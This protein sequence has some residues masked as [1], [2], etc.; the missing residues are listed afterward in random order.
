MQIYD[1]KLSDPLGEW[2]LDVDPSDSIQG[3]KQK[4][5]DE[6]LP[7]VYDYLKI[8]LFYNSVEL[9]NESTL[10]DYNIQKFSHLTAIYKVPGRSVLYMS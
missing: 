5:Q 2:S 6:E 1:Q 8:K 3:V 4:I 10:S 9:F 7:T